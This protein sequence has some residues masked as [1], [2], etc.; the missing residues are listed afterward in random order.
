MGVLTNL[1]KS[2]PDNLPARWLRNIGA[3]TV[4]DYPEKAAARSLHKALGSCEA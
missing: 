2:H 3:M 1:L 4:G